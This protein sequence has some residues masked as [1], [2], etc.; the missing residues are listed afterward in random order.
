MSKRQSTRGKTKDVKAEAGKGAEAQRPVP[1]SVTRPE[2]LIEG[3][4]RQFRRLVH[5]LFAFFA[6][7]EAIRNSYASYLGLG[8]VQYTILLA[9]RHLSQ[10][11]DV[12]VRDVAKYLRLSSSFITVESRKLQQLG[13]LDKQPTEKDRRRVVLKVTDKG[14]KLLN[15]L[16]PLQQKVNNVQFGP[17]SEKQFHEL[18]KVVERLIDSSE[19]AL[20]LL[21]Y[22]KAVGSDDEAASEAWADLEADNDEL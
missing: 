12:N 11:G 8:G 1:L 14:W 5:G 18:T 2:L 22:L 15:K 19:G 6:L 7:H 10:F 9:T 16:A 20:K 17:L 4:D 13:L 21:H 3:S